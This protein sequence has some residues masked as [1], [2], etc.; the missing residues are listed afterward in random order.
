ML[1]CSKKEI[2][3]KTMW[4]QILE[5]ESPEKKLHKILTFEQCTIFCI[6]I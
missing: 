4:D 2:N 3:K 5:I 1:I 6:A